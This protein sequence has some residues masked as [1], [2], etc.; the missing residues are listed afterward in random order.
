MREEDVSARASAIAA[1]WP[2]TQLAHL[3]GALSC[4]CLA[5]GF[6]FLFVRFWPMYAQS[7]KGVKLR[8]DGHFA[9]CF[10]V[11]VAHLRRGL[12]GVLRGALR[13]LR[14]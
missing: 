4:L 3:H 8:V 14:G 9:R 7:L 11:G 6:A 13:R 5:A 10:F 12:L 2:S 1:C